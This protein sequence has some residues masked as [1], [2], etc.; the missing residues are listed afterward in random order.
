V[1]GF[2]LGRQGEIAVTLG[3]PP[4]GRRGVQPR[5]A[6]GLLL[7]A[8]RYAALAQRHGLRAW[9]AYMP[10]KARVLHGLVRFA[11][12]AAPAV[13]NWR[14]T[15]LPAVIAELCA[16]AGIRFVDLTPALVAHT[17]RE[18]ELLYHGLFVSHLNTRGS[19]VVG[20]ALAQALRET[21]S[22]R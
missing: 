1:D 19:R 6:E 5:M 17:Q 8:R 18:G 11:P 7:F 21:A 16:N 3:F 20:E 4:R 12:D 2:F 22:G 10:A 13:R 15:D 14:P 9:L